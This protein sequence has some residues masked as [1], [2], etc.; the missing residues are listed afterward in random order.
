MMQMPAMPVARS[1]RLDNTGLTDIGIIAVLSRTLEAESVNLVSTGAT[2]TVFAMLAKLPNLKRAY[3]FD[4]KVTAQ[5]IDEFRARRPGVQIVVGEA[6]PG[7]SGT[8]G[9][10]VVP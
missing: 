7:T 2:D 8:A 9:P 6:V 5:G 3:V 1:V 10:P 4:T